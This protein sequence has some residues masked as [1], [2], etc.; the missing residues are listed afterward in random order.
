MRSRYKKLKDMGDSEF[1][2]LSGVYPET[3]KKM[4]GILRIE[5]R[6]V[7][8]RGG[9][10]EKLSLPNQLLLCLEYLR[11]Y[12]TFFH[13]GPSYGVSETTA[14]RMQKW[15]EETLIRSGE[16]TLPGKNFYKNQVLKLK[17]C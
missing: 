4:M 13:I 12:R 16:F 6:K 8:S 14:W 1:R 9:P 7:R 5:K 11:E 10:K 17:W 2:R 3:F 15:V